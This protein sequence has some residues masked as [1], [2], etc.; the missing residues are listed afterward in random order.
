MYAAADL[1]M[2]PSLEDNFPNTAL[3]AMSCGTP[4]LAFKIGGVPDLVME[5]LNGQLVPAGD[6]V[7]L[8]AALLAIL[9]NP[10]QCETWRANCR[11]RIVRDFSLAA[12]TRRYVSL[13]ESL[14]AAAP[15]TNIAGLP[16]PVPLS[17][18]PINGDAAPRL[19]STRAQ[20]LLASLE[21]FASNTKRATAAQ[22]EACRELI[23]CLREQ[24]ANPGAARDIARQRSLNEL[25][26]ELM[27]EEALRQ[28]REE[29][30]RRRTLA[31][32]EILSRIFGKRRRWT[33]EA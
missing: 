32:R 3:E 13:Y 16:G 1:Y 20:L 5:G 24:C 29:E 27:A 19:Q 8:S 26:S 30:Q 6:S 28:S 12:Q 2:L 15:V 31:R 18:L 21:H 10:Q 7:A 4:I 33:Q 11:D 23:N 22:R 25:E 17:E 14:G 9:S